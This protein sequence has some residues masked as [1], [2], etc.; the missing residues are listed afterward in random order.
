MLEGEAELGLAMEEGGEEGESRRPSESNS[1]SGVCGCAMA[2]AGVP[3][4]L[5]RLGL[6]GRGE[7]QGREGSNV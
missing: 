5:A 3:L 2:A 4:S 1:L 7:Q 6:R